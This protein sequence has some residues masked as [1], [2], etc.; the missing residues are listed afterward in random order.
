MRL[1]ILGA[2]SLFLFGVGVLGADTAKAVVACPSDSQL[3]NEIGSS[4][5]VQ[6]FMFRAPGG[7]VFESVDADDGVCLMIVRSNPSSPAT[8]YQLYLF[9]YG[10]NVSGTRGSDL[11][12]LFG[13][14]PI[15]Q[16][17]AGTTFLITFDSNRP[18]LRY[19]QIR[20]E[21]ANVHAIQGADNK[22]TPGRLTIVADTISVLYPPADRNCASNLANRRASYLSLQTQ[23]TIRSFN[24]KPVESS[25]YLVMDSGRA[26]RYS[27]GIGEES[28]NLDFD[29]CKYPGSAGADIAATAFLPDGSVTTSF[30][31]GL[32]FEQVLALPT[33][34]L[35]ALVKLS[36]PYPDVRFT[37]TMQ[38]SYGEEF[39]EDG[40]RT[41][42][43]AIGVRYLLEGDRIEAGSAAYL[44]A[45]S[46]EQEVKIASKTVKIA[47]SRSNAAA[48]GKC[49]KKS[50]K[51]KSKHSL[52]VNK[53]SIRC[54]APKK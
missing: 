24:G 19:S 16:H 39:S 36:N 21:G 7:N 33:A 14:D 2:L 42:S 53:K 28:I 41:S 4:V 48:V 51:K 12:R 31:K 6:E 17:P 47:V 3:T 40:S 50:G 46:T 45:R 18:N 22:K 34:A 44:T 52:R 26:A 35:N 29:G 13:G 30:L 9:A 32:T 49:L 43:K 27:V 15:R 38:K 54:K 20:A 23:V 5:T 8:P 1:H 11:D 37:L 10:G 25:P